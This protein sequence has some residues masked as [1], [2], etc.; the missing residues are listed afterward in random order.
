MPMQIQVDPKLELGPDTSRRLR[1]RA[2]ETGYQAEPRT[3]REEA[4]RSRR[5]PVLVPFALWLARGVE[6]VLG[7]IG[8]VWII[9]FSELANTF[10]EMAPS[11]E[12]KAWSST[13]PDG[14]IFLV[15]A[16]FFNLVSLLLMLA[17]WAPVVIRYVLGGLFWL[18]VVVYLV[19]HRVAR[20]TVRV[21]TWTA[22]VV[23]S[24]GDRTGSGSSG[25]ARR[26]PVLALATLL[27][28]LLGAIGFLE[29][30]AP[31]W[32][33]HGV[34]VEW[35]EARVDFGEVLGWPAAK[36]EAMRFYH[37]ADR[38]GAGPGPGDPDRGTQ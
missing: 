26:S 16:V 13:F 4:G 11:P 20:G 14:L 38:P 17:A 32:L 36:A 24:R 12:K 23:A 30:P 22:R 18:V 28:L 3:D 5:A 7:K 37:L 6:R 8:S 35:E 21:L 33:G 27:A 34:Q 9:V 31:A 1:E 10:S 15:G 29:V 25:R 2:A 19:L